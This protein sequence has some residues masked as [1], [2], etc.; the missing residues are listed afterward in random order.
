MAKTYG[1]H[2]RFV[3]HEVDRLGDRP[4]GLSFR[5]FLE[6]LARQSD[7]GDDACRVFAVTLEWPPLSEHLRLEVL[8]RLSAA[9]EWLEHCSEH[10]VPEDES[11]LEFLESLLIEYW[12]DVAP[13]NWCEAK[14]LPMFSAVWGTGEE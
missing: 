14:I 3:R 11:G 8:C 1:D 13:W 7:E 9:E 4:L 5:S 2:L 6:G 12:R 10:E